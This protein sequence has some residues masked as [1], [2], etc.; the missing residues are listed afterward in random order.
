MPIEGA[1]VKRQRVA[2]EQNKR[3]TIGR[4][5]ESTLNN[6]IIKDQGG[7]YLLEQTCLTDICKTKHFHNDTFKTDTKSAVRWHTVLKYIGIC[8]E[9]ALLHM[10]TFHFFKK[11]VI[12]VNSLTACCDFKTS[13][14]Q[15][16]TFGKFRSS[17]AESI[18]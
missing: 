10:I 14:K 15:V 3:A 8:T 4:P 5:Y 1:V 11:F 9:V 2:N 6:H 7:E 18:A 12:I 13:E 17:S 16:K